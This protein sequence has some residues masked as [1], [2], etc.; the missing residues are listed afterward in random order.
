MK[1]LLTLDFDERTRAY[2]YRIAI[3][4]MPILI[5][6]GVVSEQEAAVW[7]G[8]VAALLSISANTMAAK[9][10]TTTRVFTSQEEPK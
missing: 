9:N 8:V 1:K 6:Y 7:I 10:T 2:L 5:M 4:V 3:A